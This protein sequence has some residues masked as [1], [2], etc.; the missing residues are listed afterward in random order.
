MLS[1]PDEGNALDIALARDLR[2]AVQELSRDSGHILV[3]SAEGRLFCGGG[4]LAA[5]NA[6]PSPAEYINELAATM[7]EAILAL[8]ESDLIVVASV[9]GSAAGGGL[10]LVLNADYV[11]ASEKASFLSAYSAVG[12]SPDCGASYL[13]PRVVGLRRASEVLL[14]KRTLDAA[15]ALDWGLVNHVASADELETATIQA[16]NTI[17]TQPA[18]A[19]A[20]AKRLLAQNWIDGYSTH[21]DREQTSIARLTASKEST[22]LRDAFVRKG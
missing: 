19:R 5:T 11:V 8:A 10:G 17:A 13:L 16:V 12:L 6:A 7:H 15:T 9:Q 18:P 20:A 14:A 4:D 3:L 22:A 21:L 2:D 1:R